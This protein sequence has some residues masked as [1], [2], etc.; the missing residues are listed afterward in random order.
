MPR[1]NLRRL[2]VTFALAAAVWTMSGEPGG[3]AA[4][5]EHPRVSFETS[6]GSFVV[7]LDREAAPGTV[8]NFLGYVRDGHYEETVFHRVI[9]G[10]MIQGGGYTARFRQPAT[11]AP[12]RNEADNGL[13]NRR[14]TIAMAR[15]ADPH[16]A[17][18]QFF[19]NVVDN[20]FLDHRAPSPQGW[21]Y[22][23][24]GQV[25]EGMETVD[26]IAALP[27]GAGGPFP[28]DVPRDL[29]VIEKTLIRAGE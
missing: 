9:A 24:F 22:A 10:F 1:N 5:P 27:T 7:E 11:R 17:T 18:A 28:S 26:R 2:I 15:T 29:V 23:V 20:D 4:Q 12:I 19:I 14:G 25:V 16:S 3:R 6:Q 8:E 13:A 21:G